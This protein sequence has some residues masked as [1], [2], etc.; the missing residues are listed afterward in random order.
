MHKLSFHFDT[1]EDWSLAVILYCFI[2]LYFF[3]FKIKLY[4][5]A[6]FHR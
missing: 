6:L 2:L 4:C 3:N 5:Q 1:N